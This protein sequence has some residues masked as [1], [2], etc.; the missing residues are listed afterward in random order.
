LEPL[1]ARTLLATCHVTR[2]GDFGAGA[3]AGGG[4]SRGDLRYCINKANTDPGPD[5]ILFSRTGTIRLN[6]ALPSLEGDLRITGPGANLL[7]I[8][9]QQT[10]RVFY[11][12]TGANVEISGLRLTGGSDPASGGGVRN[13]GALMLRDSSIVQNG[14]TGGAGSGGSG[15]GI[16][17]TGALWIWNSSISENIND[18]QYAQG[19]GIYNS[20]TLLVHSSLISNNEISAIQF[21]G[22]GTGGGIYNS[23]TG[24]ATIIDSTI[25]LNLIEAPAAG[26]GAGIFNYGDVTIRNSLIA[27]NTILSDYP[28]GG[29]ISINGGSVTL[30]NSTVSHNSAVG[31]DGQ[32]GGIVLIGDSTLS[33]SYS[34]IA[35]NS[36]SYAGGGVYNGGTIYLYSTIVAANDSQ[37]GSDLRLF[38]GGFTS[39]G[40]NL[41]SDSS[42][43]SGYA[44]TDILDVD[45]KLGPLADNGGPTLTHALLSGSPAIDA[46]DPNPVEAPM[47]DQRGPGFSRI[48][49]GR[50]DIG[51][52]EVQATGVAR[53]APYLVLL[54]TADWDNELET[55]A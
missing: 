41:V 49:S 7:T 26:N 10:A 43:G 32:G 42:G 45:A 30:I 47:W 48:V 35:Y 36:A 14:L 31:G 51:A 52:Y 50:I 27:N 4:H 37:F 19:G 54:V 40:Y 18:N 21:S 22:L 33:A 16:Y 9:A 5:T 1:E 28:Q 20:G 8:D 29:G 25:S 46:G 38:F 15:A 39:Q 23:S 3:D 2:L 13:D 17:N 6:S 53:P 34:T 55:K 12:P 24:A 44:P 11:V